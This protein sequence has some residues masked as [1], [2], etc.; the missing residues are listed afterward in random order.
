MIPHGDP[1]Q[2]VVE[3]YLVIALHPSIFG[4]IVDHELSVGSH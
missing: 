1:S 2:Q 3:F 4:D